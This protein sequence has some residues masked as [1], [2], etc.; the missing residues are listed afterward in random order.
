LSDI[1]YYRL[2]TQHFT[3]LNQMVQEMEHRRDGQP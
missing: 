1:F 2:P 3:E